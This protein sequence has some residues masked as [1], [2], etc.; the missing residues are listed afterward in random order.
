MRPAEM[1]RFC[2][3]C[4]V[5]RATANLGQIP[6]RCEACGLVFYFNPTV[7]AAAFVRDSLG[8][9]LFIRRA[10]EPA[11]GKLGIPG[12]FIDMGETAENALR[13]EVREEVGLE[14][15]AVSFLASFPN[16]YY[17]REVSYAV[18]D[19][20]FTADA[21][22]PG[23]ANPLDGVVSLEWHHP[24]RVDPRELAFDSIRETLKLL[25]AP[26]G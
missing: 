1:F 8:R 11:K 9:V 3:R 14:L 22:A 26:V 4:G 20:V 19:L 16:T 25:R 7:S 17:F 5:A 21:V 2:P 6:L 18:V 12:G 15:E 24:A 23:T 13:R 10:L